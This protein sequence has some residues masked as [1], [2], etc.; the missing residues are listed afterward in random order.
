MHNRGLV[1]VSFLISLGKLP[2]I[3]ILSFPGFNGNETP[4]SASG[5]VQH[6]ATRSSSEQCVLIVALCVGRCAFR[7]PPVSFLV[8]NCEGICMLP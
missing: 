7:L 4:S 3:Q 6:C 8:K 2:E 1:S 5:V